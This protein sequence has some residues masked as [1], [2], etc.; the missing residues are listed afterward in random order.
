MSQWRKLVRA[1]VIKF[2]H[3]KGEQRLNI[4]IITLTGNLFKME[5]K[6]WQRNYAQLIDFV[7]LPFESPDI[8][9]LSS[10]INSQPHILPNKIQLH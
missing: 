9:K 10:R 6:I 3:E 1:A 5:I 2:S 4:N 7:P 8:L